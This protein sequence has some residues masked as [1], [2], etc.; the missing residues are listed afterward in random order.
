MVKQVLQLLCGSCIIISDGHGLRIET[1]RRNQHC[2]TKLSLYKPLLNIYSCLK[3]MYI[4]IKK[5]R[6]SFRGGC[7]THIQAL[8]EELAWAK[9]KQLRVINN[10]KQLCH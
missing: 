6:F 3:Q 5:E 4:S 2:K 8:K 1:H 9:D 10:L 7:G